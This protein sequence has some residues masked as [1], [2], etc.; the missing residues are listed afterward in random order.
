MVRVDSRIPFN[1]SGDEGH[2]T[3]HWI[4]PKIIDQQLDLPEQYKE[5]VSIYS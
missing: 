3:V 2:I 1:S 4:A 5:F